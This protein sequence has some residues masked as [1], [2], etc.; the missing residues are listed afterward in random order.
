MNEKF[1]IVI[2]MTELATIAMIQ[3]FYRELRRW[4]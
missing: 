3:E 1:H 2:D 4:L